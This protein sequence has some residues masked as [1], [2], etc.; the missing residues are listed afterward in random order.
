M[1]TQSKIKKWNNQTRILTSYRFTFEINL[2]NC[3][4]SSKLLRTLGHLK[5]HEKSISNATL[6]YISCKSDQLTMGDPRNKQRNWQPCRT[7]P[8]FK[9][10]RV[11]MLACKISKSVSGLD[12]IKKRINQEG[13]IKFFVTQYLSNILGKKIR[14]NAEHPTA[15]R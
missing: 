5:N 8:F 9:S 7:W 2:T 14:I 15:Y 4:I 11:K 13:V 6:K 1:T 3:L 12:Q 10:S